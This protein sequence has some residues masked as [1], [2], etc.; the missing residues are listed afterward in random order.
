M[1]FSPLLRIRT[2]NNASEIA[3]FFLA[4]RKDSNKDFY[5]CFLLAFSLGFLLH[6]MV[7]SNCCLKN[8]RR[9][10]KEEHVLVSMKVDGG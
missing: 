9:I 4:K 2:R 8:I 1:K 3:F 6:K 7:H 5:F 10:E